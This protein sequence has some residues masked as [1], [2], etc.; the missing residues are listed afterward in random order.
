MKNAFVALGENGKLEINLS[1]DDQQSMDKIK[2]FTKM[3][4]FKQDQSTSDNVVF[5]KPVS[6]LNGHGPP[7]IK[8]KIKEE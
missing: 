8:R 5:I 1:L 3:V 7:K 2:S 4:G 6:T